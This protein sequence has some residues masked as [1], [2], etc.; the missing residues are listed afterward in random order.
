MNR[1]LWTPLLLALLVSGCTSQAAGPP[2]AATAQ[3]EVYA[4][5]GASETYGVGATDRYREA[6]PQVFYKDVLLPPAVLHNFGIPG[7]TTA[8][9]LRD[10]V[11]AAVAVRPTLV[12]V[13]LNVNDLIQG[14]SPKDYG[15]QL[16]QL[17]HA[18]RRDGQA[19]VLVANMP[20]LSQ[21]PSY[22]AC[23]PNAPA[24]GSECRIPPGV[25]PSPDRVTA[26]VDGY[27]AVIAQVVRQQGATLVDL[28]AQDGLMAQHPEWLSSDGFHPNSLGYA[29]VARVFEDAYR[30]PS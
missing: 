19:R 9:A 5:I 30:Q 3:R 2:T 25:L 20:D 8:Q 10:E 16:E 7:A 26:A 17:V 29:A 1:R 27:N 4:A 13:W 24:G 22:Q 23:L 11:P 12:T 21:L 6:W 28:H 14:I 18:L 15:A